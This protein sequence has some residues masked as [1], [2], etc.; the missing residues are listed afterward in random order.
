MKIE[1]KN[2]YQVEYLKPHDLIDYEQ[3]AKKH[4]ADQIEKLAKEISEVGFRNPIVVDSANVIVQ[5]HGRK[6][7]AIKAG[8]NLVP[9]HRLPAN[10]SPERIR[11]MRLFDNKIA[12]TGW[13][14]EF[15]ISEL[16]YL[17]SVDFDLA[18]T[19]FEMEPE[20]EP[21][22]PDETDEKPNVESKG[23]FVLRIVFESEDQQ[24]ELFIELRD[25]GYKVKV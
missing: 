11:A 3:N 15:L 16:A 10:I 23:G 7:A 6:A 9:V 19:G 21:K 24:Q 25:R 14:D 17:Q 18:F 22:L 12:E 13:N 1:E 4:P 8:L 2:K 20:F 5:G